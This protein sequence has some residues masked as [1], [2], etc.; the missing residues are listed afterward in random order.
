[1]FNSWNIRIDCGIFLADLNMIIESNV[2]RNIWNMFLGHIWIFGII[3]C[4]WPENCLGYLSNCECNSPQDIHFGS[5]IDMTRLE[6][7]IPQDASWPTNWNGPNFNMP[8]RETLHIR[9]QFSQFLLLS[10]F[11]GFLS[12]SDALETFRSIHTHTQTYTYF[13]IELSRIEATLNTCILNPL[14]RKKR[15]TE[16]K[17]TTQN[18]A[19]NCLARNGNSYHTEKKDEQQQQQ[20]K[21][22]PTTVTNEQT[23]TTVEPEEKKW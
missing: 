20:G 8:V 14:N 21:I 7:P 19:C 1:M 6:V 2:V 5:I 3:W 10:V 18:L 17:H 11:S 12:V 16:K 9:C 4:I 23:T 13:N 15:Y 22:T